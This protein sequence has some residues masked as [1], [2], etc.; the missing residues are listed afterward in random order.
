MERSDL[1]YWSTEGG[2]GRGTENKNYLCKTN[3][4]HWAE[5][6]RSGMRTRMEPRGG[7]RDG[8]GGVAR[9]L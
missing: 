1:Y 2:E 3:K 5:M 8:G 6:R 7:I 4:E 9:E